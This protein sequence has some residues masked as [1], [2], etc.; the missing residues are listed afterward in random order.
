MS[1]LTNIIYLQG[2]EDKSALLIKDSRYLKHW[3]GNH[4]FNCRFT[5]AATS[6][7]GL[8]AVIQR[9]SFRQDQDGKCIDYVKVCSLCS[10]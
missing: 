6:G 3:T 7:L 2:I 5:V 9:M 8:F 4:E 10:C 1:F